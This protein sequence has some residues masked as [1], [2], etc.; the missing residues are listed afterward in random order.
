MTVD[1]RWMAI[2]LEEARAAA[3][4]GEVPVG[5]VVV[6]GDRLLARDHNRTRD[7]NDPTAHAEVLT[8][9]EAAVA[10]GDWR[11]TGCT[12]YVTLEPCA[13][14]AGAI[15]LARLERL[16]FATPD[17]KAGMCGSL[18]NLVQ[19]ERLNHRVTV[20]AGVAGEEAAALLREFFREKR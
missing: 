18:G 13:M 5:A 19:D 3:A 7:H 1:A 14:C 2:A 20:E 8:L 10:A 15:V 12:L 17:P 16:V 9:R 6:R 4:A 11:L